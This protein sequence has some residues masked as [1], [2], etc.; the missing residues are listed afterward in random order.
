MP[1]S[2]Q[3]TEQSPNDP[4]RMRAKSTTTSNH[5]STPPRSRYLVKR[6]TV[7]RVVSEFE[8][9]KGNF[10]DFQKT[11]GRPLQITVFLNIQEGQGGLGSRRFGTYFEVIISV[12]L[13][14]KANDTYEI[15]MTTAT[16]ILLAPFWK[17]ASWLPELIQLSV[18]KPYRLPA[19]Q[20]TVKDL[21]TWR[22]LPSLSRLRLT[23]TLI[24]AEL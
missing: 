7:T 8:G 24:S 22:D 17:R 23:V 11:S 6:K 12:C 4:P 15:R 14:V 5:P 3:L 19:V 21:T 20:S 16:L 13:P 1:Y 9:S 18:E 10:Q 2:M